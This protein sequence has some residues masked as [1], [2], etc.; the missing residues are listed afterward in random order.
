MSITGL[1]E[2][3]LDP[4]PIW[5][6]QISYEPFPAQQTSSRSECRSEYHRQTL[7]YFKLLGWRYYDSFSGRQCILRQKRANN[8]YRLLTPQH[9]QSVSFIHLYPPFFL[10]DSVLQSQY[11]L[12]CKVAVN[13]STAWTYQPNRSFRHIYSFLSIGKTVD[14]LCWT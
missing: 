11:V 1:I 7:Q 13:G 8:L 6:S 4:Q 10:R 2:I 5:I 3:H 14:I 12:Y 9:L